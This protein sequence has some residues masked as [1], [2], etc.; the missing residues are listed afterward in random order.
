MTIGHFLYIACVSG[1]YSKSDWQGWA[2]RQILKKNEV[3][4]WIYKVSLAKDIEELSSAVSDKK[5]EECY[6]EENKSSPSD[7]IVGYYY[8]Q[9]LENKISLRDLIDKLSDEDDISTASSINEYEDFYSI[10]NEIN[11][12]E[13]LLAEISFTKKIN[14]LFEPFRQ[15]AESQKKQLELY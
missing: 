4:D 15:I 10:L 9:F 1:Y 12:N 11:S 8:I 7:A 5:L 14:D 3:E 2:D 6:Y 13:C